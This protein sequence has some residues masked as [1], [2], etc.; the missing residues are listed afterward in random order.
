[1]SDKL[2]DVFELTI[3]VALLT[4]V[5]FGAGCRDSMS[6]FYMTFSLRELIKG[7]EFTAGLDCGNSGGSGMTIGT[8]G[9][10]AE[11]SNFS[12]TESCVCQITDANVFEEAKFM[13][14]LKAGVEKE[15]GANK[16]T[17]VSSK[18]AA[19]GFSVEYMSNETKGTVEISRGKGIE[20]FY[21]LQAKLTETHDAK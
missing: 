8:G 4:L 21:M 13:E 20:R 14:A 17:I 15:L 9:V 5:L 6:S 1:M 18:D 12:K 10:G 3:A 16:A 7:N 2:K 11:Q 19:G